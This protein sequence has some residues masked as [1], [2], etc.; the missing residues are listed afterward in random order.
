MSVYMSCIY[1]SNLCSTV[2]FNKWKKWTT[3]IHKPCD[4]PHALARILFHVKCWTVSI[5]ILVA[6][7]WPT[8]KL[9]WQITLKAQVIG[10]R[11]G[12]TALQFQAVKTRAFQCHCDACSAPGGHSAGCRTSWVSAQYF[13]KVVTSNAITVCG[14]QFP[15]TVS[16]HRQNQHSAIHKTIPGMWNTNNPSSCDI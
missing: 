7:I 14:S 11:T 16:K 12:R 8:S 6:Y 10:K 5:D 1:S 4:M 2:K 3:L 13:A 9:E 15:P